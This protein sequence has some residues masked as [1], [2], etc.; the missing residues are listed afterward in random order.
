[1]NRGALEPA[2]LVWAEEELVLKNISPMG[3][4]ETR[5]GRAV[6]VQVLWK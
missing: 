2:V 1:M 5:S 6:V 3:L 4:Y